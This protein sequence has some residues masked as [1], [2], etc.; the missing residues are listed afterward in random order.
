M[1]LPGRLLEDCVATLGELRP[2]TLVRELS[3]VHEC[4]YR[5]P[6]RELFTRAQSDADMCRGEVVLLVA[7][8]DPAA[9]DDAAREALDRVLGILLSELPLKQAAH[10][11]AQIC[12]V[13]DNESYKRALKLKGG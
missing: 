11:A 2:A 10:L 7:G 1:R 4:T 6:L 9:D 5:G 8:A 12:N 13:R 3:K